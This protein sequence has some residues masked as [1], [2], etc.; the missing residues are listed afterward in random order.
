ME[1]PFSNYIACI[2]SN[3]PDCANLIE[4]AVEF[5]IEN[6]LCKI[7][8][9][10]PVYHCEDSM[11]GNKII[12][13]KSTYTIDQLIREIKSF[14]AVCGRNPEKKKAGIIPI[15]IDILVADG[16]ILRNDYHTPYVQQGL[17][18]LQKH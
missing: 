16:K 1:Q 5:L 12:N 10:S 6:C 15:D 9:S 17:A 14:E 8:E 4:K 3:D 18:Y 2:G 11:Y 7:I 13:F